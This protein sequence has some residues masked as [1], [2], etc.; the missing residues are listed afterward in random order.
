MSNSFS[1]YKHILHHDEKTVEIKDNNYKELDN[2]QREQIKETSYDRKN[3]ENFVISFDPI[4]FD[5][6]NDI[7][8]KL[9]KY[10]EK[11]SKREF[12]RNNKV[13]YKTK[14]GKIKEYNYE[15]IATMNNSLI[16]IHL[17]TNNPHIH[18]IFN[19]K[20]KD[21]SFGK[22]YSTLKKELNKID[23]ELNIV[24]TLS[25]DKEQ[26]SIKNRDFKFKALE[27]ELT[28]F[29]WALEKNKNMKNFKSKEITLSNIKEKLNE[30]VQNNGSYSFAEKI[31]NKLI[32]EKYF[33]KIEIEK[34]KEQEY[35]YKLVQSNNYKN[36]FEKTLQDCKL[37]KPLNI[38]IRKFIEKDNLNLFEKNL[39]NDLIELYKISSF[40]YSDDMKSKI[41]N[42]KEIE[43]K[44]ILIRK[45]I[46]EYEKSKLLN[47][48]KTKY[49]KEL[50][51]RNDLKSINYSY[52]DFEK[53]I[54]KSISKIIFEN[55]LDYMR[56][57]IKDFNYEKI[58]NNI[59]EL[60]KELSDNYVEK[61]AN[62]LNEERNNTKIYE[63]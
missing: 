63:R 34:S 38:E 11:L 25:K 43:E 48:Q 61:I 55:N 45:T 39:K 49:I 7:K 42:I 50:D 41:I 44:E 58:K 57:N 62:H 60:N 1:I 53:L 17:N 3:I 54:E 9:E 56:E 13:K 8:E 18:V 2:E 46:D 37:A 19:K 30:Y 31:K 33:E 23:N 36:I 27:K 5:S 21:K 59:K 10:I 4:Q 29:S 40:K 24:T 47:I 20:D 22:N 15:R 6:V 14:D 35:V 52:N 51:L 16:S 32:E 26:A 12:K 28:K